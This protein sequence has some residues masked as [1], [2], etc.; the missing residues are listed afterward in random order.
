M[1]N[2]GFERRYNEVPKMERPIFDRIM[3]EHVEMPGFPQIIVTRHFIYQW[4]KSL[5]WNPSERGFSSLDYTTFGRASV[6]DELTDEATRD[7]YLIP[8]KDVYA[9]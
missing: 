9:R 1:E 2:T 8:L 6:Q 3:A 5:G 7:H 4:L